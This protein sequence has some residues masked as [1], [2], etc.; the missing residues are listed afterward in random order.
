MLKSRP[1][2]GGG[3]GGSSGSDN[4]E[5][6]HRIPDESEWISDQPIWDS[7]QESDSSV[8]EQE[9]NKAPSKL[10]VD[11]DF[12]YQ[13]D[14]NGN[15]T[16]LIPNTGRLRKKR[17]YT[18]VEYDQTAA[19]MHHASDLDIQLPSDFNMAKYESLD[20][21]GRLDYVNQNVPREIVIN[22]QNAIGQS[23]C[24]IFNIPGKTVSV[25]GFAGK[26]KI[27]TELTIQQRPDSINT[28]SI[29]REDGTHIASF[30][31][32]DSAIKKLIKNDFWVLRDRNL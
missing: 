8:S 5:E 25:P 15:P 27:G 16:L 4:V 31:V 29:I 19:H 32:D 11:I 12:P 10:E 17:T 24:P 7:A 26:H 22:Y 23:M 13:Y 20:R 30:S 2:L 1:P 28:L 14:S 6:K 18:K 21:A 3:S 9:E